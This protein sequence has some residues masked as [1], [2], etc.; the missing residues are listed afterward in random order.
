MKAEAF[1]KSM[2]FDVWQSNAIEKIDHY[3]AKSFA[4]TIDTTD[5]NNTPI[6]LSLDYQGILEQA[7][8]QKESFK[9]TT[10]EIKKLVACDSTISVHFYSSSTDKRTNELK[11]RCVCGIWRLNNNNKID[12]VW[13]VVTPYYPT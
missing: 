5:S 9:N 12:R 6:T 4:E 2:Y 13:A 1:F 7:L 11:H 8:F 3:Y 10:F